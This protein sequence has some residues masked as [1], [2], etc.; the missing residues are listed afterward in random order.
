MP[1][2]RKTFLPLS[3]FLFFPGDFLKLGGGGHKKIRIYVKL[4]FKYKQTI[5]V[6]FIAQ[7][8]MEHV[9]ITKTS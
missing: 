8:S 4:T 9:S 3:V 6:T 1:G 2:L 5:Y 7:K